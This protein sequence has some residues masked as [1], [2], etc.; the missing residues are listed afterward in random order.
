M[1][2]SRSGSAQKK[3]PTDVQANI[4]VAEQELFIHKEEANAA[5]DYHNVMTLRCKVEWAEIIQ[6]LQ[7]E[8]PSP[9]AMS[10]LA[11]AQHKFILV[12][13]AD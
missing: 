10:K 2:L 3:E 9:K 1:R 11:V 13:S 5:R 4:E 12:L 7:E 8:N 6:L